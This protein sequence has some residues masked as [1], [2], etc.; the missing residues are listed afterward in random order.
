MYSTAEEE[1][2]ENHKI[3]ELINFRMIL[4]LWLQFLDEKRTAGRR[5]IRTIRFAS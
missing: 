2:I 5:R 3:D 4:K 1:N